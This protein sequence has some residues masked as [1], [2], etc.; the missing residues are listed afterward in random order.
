MKRYKQ[1]IDSLCFS[2]GFESDTIALMRQAANKRE[3]I[4]LNTINIR[5]PIR[6]AI[7]VAIIAALLTGTVFAMSR[8]LSASQVA[9]ML[10]ENAIA[11]AFESED[12]VTINE[13]QQA[14]DYSITLH[15][16]VSGEGIAAVSGE[17]NADR[18]YIVISVA[19]ADGRAFDPCDDL[20]VHF[21]PLIDGYEPWRVNMFSL[22]S[23]ALRSSVDGVM[24]CLYEMDDLE[25]FADSRVRIFG[26]GCEYLAPSAEVFSMGA[27]GVI[28]YSEAYSGLRVVFELPMDKSKADPKAVQEWLTRW[29]EESGAAD[30]SSEVALDEN[31]VYV[32]FAAEFLNSPGATSFV[33][34]YKDGEEDKE[35]M[36]EKAEDGSV[37]VYD[38]STGEI[39]P[40]AEASKVLEFFGFSTETVAPTTVPAN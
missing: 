14:G 32:N 3:E 20:P 35:Y 12:A 40:E 25:M 19:Y 9:D 34:G 11:R 26:Y 4:A 7:A 39:V 10:E 27:D 36:V 17:V 16:I 6:I 24:Y 38:Y 15:G 1:G 31:G 18:S 21:T 37:T 5:K 29:E 13:T 28:D 2:E 30:N 8:L 22:N 33:I 23:S